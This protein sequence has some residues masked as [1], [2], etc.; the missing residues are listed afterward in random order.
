MDDLKPFD[1]SRIFLPF[2][3]PIDLLHWFIILL[4]S[5]QIHLSI[6]ISFKVHIFSN[7]LD[8]KWQ[9]WE[10]I[11]FTENWFPHFRLILNISKH[12]QFERFLV[13][14]FILVMFENKIL[15]YFIIIFSLICYIL[16]LSSICKSIAL[17]L[18]HIYLM[19]WKSFILF[20]TCCKPDFVKSLLHHYI[21]RPTLELPRRK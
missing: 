5:F 19:H 17:K 9:F 10:I 20:V 4:K 3:W 14:V 1:Q 18:T 13:L 12:N 11:V 21:F 2:D 8:A 15:S 16:N 6:S 7:C